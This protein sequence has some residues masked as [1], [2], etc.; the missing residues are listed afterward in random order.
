MRRRQ[1]AS[2]SFRQSFRPEGSVFSMFRALLLSRVHV[3]PVRS[4]N[5]QALPQMH[6][7]YIKFQK[8]RQDQLTALSDRYEKDWGF[9][10]R[11]QLCVIEKGRYPTE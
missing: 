1:I 4:R 10:T 5:S 8:W 3:E 7:I 11:A 9:K 2:L 6:P